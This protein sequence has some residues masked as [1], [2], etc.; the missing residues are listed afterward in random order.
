[1]NISDVYESNKKLIRRLNAISSR[2]LDNFNKMC[3]LEVKGLKDSLE[4]RKYYERYLLVKSIE[5]DYY[6]SL[7]I[8]MNKFDKLLSFTPE[9]VLNVD[10][11]IH[12]LSMNDY[13]NITYVRVLQRLIHGLCKQDDL[14]VCDPESNDYTVFLAMKESGSDLR[15]IEFN[16]VTKE[17]YKKLFISYMYLLDKEN[18]SLMEV[19]AKYNLSYI[20][21]E[22]EEELFK[23]KDSVLY[24]LG[25]D[26][27]SLK[28]GMDEANIHNI[29]NLLAYAN[30]MDACNGYLSTSGDNMLF[31]NLMKT[32]LMLMD[33]EQY[34][35]MVDKINTRIKELKI[36][37]AK[38][39][40]VLNDS[41]KQR[42]KVR[43]LSLSKGE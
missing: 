36:N 10:D 9:R 23:E 43:V 38:L 39:Y 34:K 5:D 8:N 6:K 19:K 13:S 30:I 40:R 22:L 25:N 2:I 31:R 14:C 28:L 12:Y 21:F 26:I 17:F 11:I 20:Y 42:S 29:F 35:F 32:Y 18:S 4:Y 41:K 1:M 16:K 33:S 3:E 27:L 15:Y 37:N 7:N 24:Y